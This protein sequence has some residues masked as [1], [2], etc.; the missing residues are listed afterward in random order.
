MRCDLHGTIL[1]DELL[2]K[3]KSNGNTQ[4]VSESMNQALS[5]NR[6]QNWNVENNLYDEV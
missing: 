1:K 3:R 2:N 4:T 6:Y 5:R